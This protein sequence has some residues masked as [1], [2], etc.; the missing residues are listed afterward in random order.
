MLH[1]FTIDNLVFGWPAFNCTKL[2]R[3][4]VILKVDGE[5]VDKQ[6][7]H[8]KLVGNDEPWSQVTL[9]VMKGGEGCKVIG[10]YIIYILVYF[11]FDASRCFHRA[12][13]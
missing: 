5:E 2:D 3:G 12:M 9:T 8:E 4:D 7:I 10:F 1:D 11:E 6:T 13:S